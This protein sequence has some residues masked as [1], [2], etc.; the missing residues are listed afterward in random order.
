MKQKLL[1]ASLLLATLVAN[2]AQAA[3]EFGGSG[4]IGY[5]SIYEFRGVDLGSDMV[6]ASAG[7]TATY[8]D[9]VLGA[10]LWYAAVNDNP[11]NPT[12][13]ELDMT[14]SFTKP[15]GPVTLTGGYI[16]YDFENANASNTQELYL[17]ASMEVYAGISA[18][19]T[20]FRDIDLFDG[21]YFDVNLSKSFEL[22]PCLS[23]VTTA[24]CGFAD[25]NGLQ[26][27]SN[28]DTLDGFNQ[29]Y[30][31]LSMPWKFREGFTLTPFLKY[32]DADSDL[33]SDIPGGSTGDDHLVYGLKL[34]FEF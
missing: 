11:T 27:Q 28:G 34:G 26:L 25:D 14:L 29:W 30:L 8:G 13:N 18:S 5:N 15:L 16:Y 2:P 7:L 12:P 24:G 9:L 21:W 6:E 3:W 10:S 33:V 1:P 31:S 22:S 23:L 32:V 17:G 4:A 19:T 20:V